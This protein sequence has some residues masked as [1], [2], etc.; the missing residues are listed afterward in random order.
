MSERKP[1]SKKLR[2]EV[3]KRDGFACQ[4]CGSNPPSVVL[5]IDHINPV[6]NGGNN[7]IDNLITACFDCNRGKSSCLLSSVPG[8]VIDKTELITEKLEQVKAYERIIK[9]R[10]KHEEKQIN[11]VQDTFNLYF[12]GYSFSKTFK[13]SVRVFVK[14]IPIDSVTNAMQ[15]ACIKFPAVDD[16]DRV[17]KYFCGICWRQIRDLQE[18]R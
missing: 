4:Y 3:F 15:V 8:S 2:F 14:N 1:L 18:I 7:D 16:L 9:S 6:S 17:I 11:E 13:E 5:E 10:K 12:E